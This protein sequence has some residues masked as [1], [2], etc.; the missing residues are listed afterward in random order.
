MKKALWM[1]A[2][3]YCVC[4]FEDKITAIILLLDLTCKYRLQSISINQGYILSTIQIKI[5]ALFSRSCHRAAFSFNIC[6]DVNSCQFCMDSH[7]ENGWKLNRGFKVLYF[8]NLIYVK[9][10][11]KSF[12]FIFVFDF[13]SIWCANALQFSILVVNFFW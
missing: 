3:K 8:K 4:V 12:L 5:F 1:L 2:L 11:N 7:L 10:E 13:H 6:R 9:Y